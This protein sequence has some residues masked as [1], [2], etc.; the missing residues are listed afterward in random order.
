MTDKIKESIAFLKEQG[1]SDPEIGIILGTGLGHMMDHFDIIDTIGYEDIPHFPVSTVEF[2]PGKLIYG[3]LNGKTILAMQGRF[4][5][6][7]GYELDEITYPIRVMRMLGIQYLFISN[8]GGAMN[9]SMKK[10]DLMLIEDHINMI[11]GSPLRGKEHE[12]FGSRFVDLSNPYSESLNK[13]IRE[14]AKKLGIQL[15]K[16]VYVAVSGPHLET[17]AEYRYLKNAGADVVGMSTAPEVIVA[18]QMKL[19]VA[20]ISVLT[21]ECDPDHLE[22]VDIKDILEVAGIAEKK[23][24]KLLKDVIISL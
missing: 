5:Y 9:L 4:H 24:V 22:K 14:S 8:A 19:P 20:A 11:P 17:R 15:H 12:E 7:E 10:G 18:N 3:K 13:K 6:Y 1:I 2:H 16:G 21:D 23:L